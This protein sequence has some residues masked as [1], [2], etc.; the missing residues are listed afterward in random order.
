MVVGQLYFGLI[1]D[2]YP[3]AAEV[4]AA[5]G[6]LLQWFTAIACGVLPHVAQ[7]CCSVLSDRTTNL[8]VDCRMMCWARVVMAK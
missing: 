6:S 4:A 8:P 7:L 5:S 1:T 3:S 2:Y